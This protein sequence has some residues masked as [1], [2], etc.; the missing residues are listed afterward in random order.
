MSSCTLTLKKICSHLAM[1]RFEIL[2]EVHYIFFLSYLFSLCYAAC[3]ESVWFYHFY[4]YVTCRFKDPQQL[5]SF[6]CFSVLHTTDIQCYVLMLPSPLTKA[7]LLE[8]GQSSQL[9]SQYLLLL[10]VRLLKINSILH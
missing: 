5:P 7:S 10:L 4:L 8:Y 3:T 2:I 1:P 6:I 9:A